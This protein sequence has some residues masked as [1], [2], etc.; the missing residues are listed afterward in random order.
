LLAHVAEGRF[1]KDLGR[2]GRG[3]KK[4]DEASEAAGNANCGTGAPKTSR[5][6]SSS[7]D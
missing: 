3:G 1:L 2:Y 6:L 5:Y 7:K 4:G